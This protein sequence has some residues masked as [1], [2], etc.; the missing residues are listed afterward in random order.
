MPVV[1]AKNIAY[2]IPKAVFGTNMGSYATPGTVSQQKVDY[3]ISSKTSG[4]MIDAF[5]RG[6]EAGAKTI[7]PPMLQN[8]LGGPQELEGD[9][10]GKPQ[11]QPKAALQS[12]A[13][14][15]FSNILP[16]TLA[17]KSPK[18]S[19]T[20]PLNKPV[21]SLAPDV[22]TKDVTTLRTE[23]LKSGLQE[24]N[25]RLKTAQ[26]SFSENTIKRKN[27]EGGTTTITP[28]DTLA[29]N[30]IIPEVKSGKIQMGDYR[31]GEGP[32]GKLKAR[33]EE[34]DVEIDNTLVSSGKVHQIEQL[35]QQAIAA[36]KAD[37][38]IRREGKVAARTKEIEN[39][40]DD[41]K[42]S[43]GETIDVLEI[44]Q[45]RKV[46]NKD[47]S[48]ETMDTSRIVGD[49]AREKVYTSTKDGKVKRLL[50]EQ[51]ELLAARKY[52][53]II[54]GTAVT[55]GRLG[56]YALRTGGAIIGSTTQLPVLGPILGMLGGEYSARLLQ[57][58]QFKSLPAELKALF[59]RPVKQKPPKPQSK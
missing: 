22:L 26:K 9:A 10:K 29:K 32:L 6:P 5:L 12:L 38:Q 2:D 51:G 33:V 43:Y 1:G 46:A 36:V 23:K 3:P 53:E 39:R 42:N 16:Y 55:G 30:G 57:Q 41:Y 35:K 40:F 52:A 11:L 59:S 56:N 50:D 18:V 37:T 54:N 8:F 25:T 13:E 15:P 14:K 34:I 24:Q 28:I 17:G 48:P 49:V 19:K 27:P 47:Y 44:N 4:A 58:S 21:K 31:A 45:I 7:L 20:S